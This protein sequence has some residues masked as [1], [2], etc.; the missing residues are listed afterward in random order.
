MSCKWIEGNQHITF[1]DE[2][3]VIK[4]DGHRYYKRISGLGIK[5]VDFIAIDPDWGL[6]F[7]EL[8]DYP[9]LADVPTHSSQHRMLQSKL[10]GSIKLIK[11]VNKALGRQ[12]YYRLIFLR[13][14]I[15]KLCPY[16][17]QIW[18]EAEECIAHDRYII[19]GDFSI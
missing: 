3:K 17:W 1:P 14:R 8:K 4:L 6:F 13:L 19:I 5:A 10:Q 7:I 11:T 2:W 12:W 15:Y 9:A 18:K 16:E